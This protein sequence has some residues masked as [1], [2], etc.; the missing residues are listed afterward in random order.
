MT[1]YEIRLS[2]CDDS[3]SFAMELADAEAELMQRVAARSKEASEFG[4]QPVMAVGP[5]TPSDEVPF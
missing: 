5:L 2:G 1:V 3:T 4:C